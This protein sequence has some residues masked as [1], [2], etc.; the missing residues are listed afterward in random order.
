MRSPLVIALSLALTTAVHAAEGGGAFERV[1]IGARVRLTL[2]DSPELVNGSLLGIRGDSLR[3][4]PRGG[5]PEVSVPV[6]SVG[7]MSYLESV[8]PSPRKATLL[9]IGLGVAGGAVIGLVAGQASGEGEGG[10]GGEGG[11]SVRDARFA[12]AAV[13]PAQARAT[14]GYR[15]V[16]G[17]VVGGVVGGL[18]GSLTGLG[19]TEAHWTTVSPAAGPTS[20]RPAPAAPAVFTVRL[21]LP[22]TGARR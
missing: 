20:W 21:P 19:M 13:T 5:G 15:T 8:L 16:L 11:G 6:A 9:G 10:G 17:G 7:S 4:A 22:F 12:A 18:L 14:E 1:P 2:A 3:V